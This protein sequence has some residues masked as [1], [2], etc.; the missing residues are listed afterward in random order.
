[1]RPGTTVAL[2]LLLAMIL[3][4]SAIQLVAALL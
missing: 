1:M 2:G 3:L 4:A